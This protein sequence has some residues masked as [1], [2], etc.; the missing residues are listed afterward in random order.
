MFSSKVSSGD[1]PPLCLTQ[2]C[3]VLA[4]QNCCPNLKA[5]WLLASFQQVGNSFFILSVIHSLAHFPAV[6]IKVYTLT[7]NSLYSAD[8]FVMW[9]S[10]TNT[11]YMQR[12]LR[13]QPCESSGDDTWPEPNTTSVINTSNC[14]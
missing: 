7:A 12:L 14:R 1:E 2:L 11:V 8:C 13:L 6:C 5:I 4:S 10:C 9:K 3:T